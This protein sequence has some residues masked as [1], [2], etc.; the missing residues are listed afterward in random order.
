MSMMTSEETSLLPS[1]PNRLVLMFSSRS[2][3]FEAIEGLLGE[4]GMLPLVLADFSMSITDRSSDLTFGRA[5]AGDFYMSLTT[6][7][8]P[9]S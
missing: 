9:W 1:N 3:G 2:L 4:L 8:R 7:I 6:T 5:V